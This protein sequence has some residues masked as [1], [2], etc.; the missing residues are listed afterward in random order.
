M[1]KLNSIE[2]FPD[3]F[4]TQPN[5]FALCNVGDRV[6]IETYF[7][8]QTLAVASSE[9]PITL[10]D[11][12]GLI[13]TGWITSDSDIFKDFK[14]GDT[15]IWGDYVEQDDL[16]S[17]TVVD[18]LGDNKLQLNAPLELLGVSDPYESTNSVFSVSVPIKGIKYQYNW[19]E[20]S[21]QPS[22]ISE[23][24]GSDIILMHDDVDAG[25]NTQLPMTFLGNLDYQVGSATVEGVAIVDTYIYTSKFRIVHYTEVTPFLLA[26]IN[27]ATSLN[28][29]DSLK[30]G[31]N[32]AD[33]INAKCVK[34]I[35]KIG[36]YYQYTDPNRVQI[37]EDTETLGDTGGFSENF[38]TGLTNY[39]ISTQF[40]NAAF[41]V[42]PSLELTSN[43][44]YFTITITN[45]T[46]VPFNVLSTLAVINFGK[47]ASDPGEYQNTGRTYKEN[48]VRDMAAKFVGAGI[49]DGEN[50]GTDYQVIENVNLTFVSGSVIQ[51]TGQI[52]FGAEA[53]ARLSESNEPRY[54]LWVTAADYRLSSDE[55]D[56]VNLIASLDDFYVN[57]TAPG[58]IVNETKFIRHPENDFD[59]AGQDE[60]GVFPYDEVVARAQFQIDRTLYPT[61]IVSL[62]S[63]RGRIKI[64]NP[65]SGMEFVLDSFSINT[66]G[67]GLDSSGYQYIDIAQ[68]RSYHIPDTEPRKN[69]VIKRR[70][71]LDTADQFF[72]DFIFPFMNRW[73][74]W[75][76]LAGVNAA[77]FNTG[78]PNNGQNHEW[79]RYTSTISGWK[80]Y[81]EFHV[82]FDFNGSNLTETFESEIV[83]GEELKP[84]EPWQ[85][86]SIKSYDPDTSAELYDPAAMK[87]FL[88]G[89]KPT[90]IEVI[91]LKEAVFSSADISV[92]SPIETFEEGGVN[93]RRRFSSIQP[94]ASDTWMIGITDVTLIDLDF[95]VSNYVKARFLVDH[96]SLLSTNRYKFTIGGR[97]FEISAELLGGKIT[98]S[99]VQKLTEGLIE[100]IIE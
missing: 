20:N 68:P 56:R 81:F 94:M 93:G 39:S 61:D 1:I 90:L 35:Y 51:M 62:K 11:T 12:D 2:I 95:A 23:V 37:Y 47:V 22:Y 29:Y 64:K 31:I 66:L 57:I 24:D 86:I 6:R 59:L 97:L 33:Y 82:V 89:Y 78:E 8:V 32:R 54:I 27:S 14:V 99:G 21:A 48:F 50:H 7:T 3:N 58:L 65:T 79:N 15:V 49:A 63:L 28:E 74:Y 26:K 36:G 25:N 13:G 84:S 98:E 67:L 76:A 42:I 44:Q 16:E 75:E 40:K 18:K 53:L 5:D 4:A 91:F 80:M 10:N 85:F 87:K 70:G 55:S 92:L 71:D 9:L 19:K 43:V 73:E 77:F 72:Y 38:N 96:N 34:F 69:I 17:F 88:L 52:I 60:I 45:T 100:K 83:N 41:T 30:N 46:D